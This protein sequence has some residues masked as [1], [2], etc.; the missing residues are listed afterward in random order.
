METTA[1][2]SPKD[3]IRELDGLRGMAILAVL[4]YHYVAIADSGATPNPLLL[5]FQHLFGIGWAGVDLF[6]VLSGFLIGGILLDAR[7]A[8]HYF[9]TFYAHAA[10]IALSRCTTI[11]IGIFLHSRPWHSTG[12][13]RRSLTQSRTSE[14]CADLSP[15]PSKFGQNSARNFR[16]RLAGCT[17]VA[18]G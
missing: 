13:H 5:R 18:G 17:M 7:N 1:E 14:H 12:C 6:F 15:V 2:R 16:D 4:F 9:S 3:R 8:S 11:W 10:F